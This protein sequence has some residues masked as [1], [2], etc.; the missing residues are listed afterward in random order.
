MNDRKRK[1]AVSPVA[2][3]QPQLSSDQLDEIHFPDLSKDQFRIGGQT[4]RIR[5]MPWRWERIFRKA[6]M[7]IVESELKPFERAIYMFA[8]DLSIVKEDLGFTHSFTESE[9]DADLYLTQ[10]VTIMCLS[11]DPEILK[12]ATSGQEIPIQLQMSLEAKY[13]A[14]IENSNEWPGGSARSYLREVV[15]KQCEKMD[16]VQTLGKSL[17]RRFEELSELA[18][19]K[20]QFDSLKLGF[21]Q[22]VQKFMGKAG[23]VVGTPARSSSL[24]TD[25]GSATKPVETPSND[26]TLTVQEAGAVEESKA[27]SG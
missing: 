8:S 11:Q 7:P 6:C 13:T 10:C 5:I 12:L 22:Q 19:T 9:I 23:S 17:M 27:A 1:S 26:S 24:S 18:G 16:L 21:S 3:E 4:F 25:N 2:T 20:S 14:M 15:R